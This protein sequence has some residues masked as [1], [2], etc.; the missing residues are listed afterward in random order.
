M[1]FHNINIGDRAFTLRLTSKAIFNYCKKHGTDGGSP[2]I[3]ILEAVNNLE[4]KADLL[5]HALNHPDNKNSV[6]DGYA[7]LD[8]MAD[9][10][11]WKTPLAKNQLILDLALEAGLLDESEYA[12]LQEPVAKSS[13]AL[14]DTMAKL[15]IGA[16]IGDAATTGDQPEHEENPT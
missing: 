3:A 4:A 13:K 14:I 8:L 7:L 16:P 12:E 1:N 11:E 15:L 5:T 2:I 10:S 9:D 6:R